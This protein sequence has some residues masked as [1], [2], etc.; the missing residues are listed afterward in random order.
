MKLNQSV[1]TYVENRPRYA[2]YTFEKLFPDVL[3]H[4]DSEHNKLKGKAAPA[5]PP[6]CR[7]RLVYY[8]TLARS[9][10]L[11]ASVSGKEAAFNGSTVI[12]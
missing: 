11:N 2:G 3:F 6:A 5:I 1:R 8:A 4:A 12:L 9:S 10:P 7:I